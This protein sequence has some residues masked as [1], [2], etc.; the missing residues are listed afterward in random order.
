MAPAK[1]REIQREAQQLTADPRLHGNWHPR[2]QKRRDGGRCT[3]RVPL[4]SALMQHHKPCLPSYT[5]SQLHASWLEPPCRI[6][7]ELRS[8]PETHNRTPTRL[9]AKSADEAVR[10]DFSAGVGSARGAGRRDARPRPVTQVRQV[11]SGAAQ[12]HLSPEAAGIPCWACQGLHKITHGQRF[13]ERG[14]G[15]WRRVLP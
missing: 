8:Q 14:L 11:R 5:L 15:S 7:T 3:Q 12:A 1:Q 6:Q 4:L 13:L 10:V 2:R 9:Q